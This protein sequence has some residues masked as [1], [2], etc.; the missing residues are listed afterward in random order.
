MDRA[1]SMAD[2]DATHEGASDDDLEVA[3]LEDESL[4][5]AVDAEKKAQRFWA[6]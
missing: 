6:V 4:E 2:L 5:A 1:F 3:R